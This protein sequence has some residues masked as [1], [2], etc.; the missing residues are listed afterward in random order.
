GCRNV[1]KL[2]VPEG[3]DFGF[4]LETLHEYRE[5]VNHNKYKNNFDYTLTLWLLNQVP[6][7]NNGC[8][9]LKEEKSLQA[10]IASVHYEFYTGM[11]P[12]TAELQAR[13]DEIQCVVGQCSLPPVPV[14]PFGKSQEPELEDYADGVDTLDFL[15]KL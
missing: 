8:L 14:L 11:A 9:L 15:T 13:K 7:Q 6:Y 3:Y 10:R 5:I 4:L 12:L 1:S 2:Y